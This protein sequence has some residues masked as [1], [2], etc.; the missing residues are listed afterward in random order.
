MRTG[1]PYILFK[2]TANRALPDFL[3]DKG[4]EIKQSNICSEIILPTD[5]E[6]TAVCCLSSLNLEYWDEWK[7][8]YQFYYD[9]A[10]ML[11]NVLDMFISKAPHQVRRAVYSASRER[12]IGIG[13][14]GF[15]A[16]LQKKN[17]PFESAL[18][19][20]L[21]D[22]IFSLY[23]KHLDQTNLDLGKLRGEAPDAEGTGKRFSHMMAIAPNASTS[24]IMGNTSPSIEP[25]R[26][27]AYRQDTMSGSYLKKNKYLDKIIQERA[28]NPD[29]VWASIVTAAGSVQHIDFLTD[30]EKDVFK[31]ATEINQLWIIGHAAQRQKYIDQAQSVNLF[32]YPEADIT[33]IHD[34]H[35]SAWKDGLK[36]LYYCRSNKIYH[37]EAMNK[38][39][40]RI[41]LDEETC[42]A[43]EG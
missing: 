43:C 9:V 26:A 16:L 22:Q 1:E 25:Y 42:L 39:V 21:N 28:K 34:I 12:S 33:Y 3:K 23:K 31:T 24:L 7:D 5:N 41:K 29:E 15:H 13:A 10:E 38:Q 8:N 14:L 2:D 37:G 6:R 36:T 17:I 40:K 35:F 30:W 11:D 32:F 4:L 27:N 20:S 19:V 18:A